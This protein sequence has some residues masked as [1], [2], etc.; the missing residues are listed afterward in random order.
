MPGGVLPRRSLVLGGEAAAPGWVA[1]VVAAAGGRGVFNHYGPTEATIGVATGRLDAGGVVPVGSPVANTRLFVLDRRLGPVPAG[2]TGEL[3]IAGAQLARGYLGRPGLTGERFVACPFG[4]GE[5]MYRTG[6]VAR[7]TAA[8]EVVFCGRADEQVK[9]RGFR[10][11]PGEVEAVLAGHPGVARGAVTVRE[12]VPGDKRLVG[13]VV[14]VD[15]DGEAGGLAGRV[16]EHAAG[17]LPDYMVPSAVVVLDALPLT[18][19]GKLDRNALPVPD[20]A[21]GAAAGA[22]REPQT[23]PEEIICGLFADVLGLT[24][25]GPDDDFFA[26]GGHSLLAV[27]LVSRV[28]AVL[29]VEVP[30]QALFAAPTPA[31]LAGWLGQAGPARLALAPRLRPDRVPLSFAQQRLWFIAQLE[32]PTPVYNNPVAIRLEGDL[33]AGALEA[34]LGDVIGRHEVLRTVFPAV[35]GEPCQ[36]VIEVGELGWSLAVTEVA[37]DELAGAVAAVAGQPFDLTAEIPVRARLLAVAAGI[38]VLVVVIHHIATDGWSTGLLARDIGAA[39]VARKAGQGP[40]WA[41]LPVQYADYAIWQRELLGDEG[42]PASL[43]PGQVAWW[44]DALAGAPPELTLPADRPRPAVPGHGGHTVPLVV[45]AQEHAGLVALARAQ[46]VTVFMVVQAALAALLSKLGAGEDIPVGTPVA[47]RSDEAL[48]DLV[49]FFVNSLVL[50]TD[51]SG[52]PAFTR[53]LARVREFWLGALDHQDVPFER[54]VEVLAPERSLGRHPLFQVN[55]TVQNNAPAVLALPGLGATAMPAG[56][57]PA[58]Y[59]LNIILTET[60][61]GQGAVGGLHGTV[62]AAADLFDPATAHAVSDRFERVLAA[63]VADP[64]VRMRQVQVL[65]ETER[66]QVVEGW[67]DTARPVRRR[68]CLSWLRRWWR[69]RLMRWRWRVVARG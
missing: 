68:R 21:A 4:S 19:N 58:R 34:A 69:G 64:G 14:P 8:G 48:D 13:Y 17:R 16:R 5:R 63:V 46:G 24:Q 55:L 3:Y 2:V 25:A 45:G 41:A 67:N 43:L 56:E 31:A 12:D 47:G 7:W 33:D 1:S 65:T 37:E 30:V 51:V 59:D 27:R 39:Y 57:P 50:R 15:A 11:E 22:G 42:D 36:Q 61:D 60:R 54:L 52:D 38:H 29:D 10:V 26:L 32:G 53:L 20:Y 66:A 6:D 44:R 35:D 49:G 40:G 23:V 9:V 28:R 62:T 18:S